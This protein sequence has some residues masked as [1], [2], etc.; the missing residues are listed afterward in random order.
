MIAAFQ[1]WWQGRS[2]RE[3]M[4]L[5]SMFAL[6]LICIGWFAI[7]DS[8]QTARVFAEDRLSRATVARDATSGQ[9]AWI[10]SRKEP[11]IA[12]IPLADLVTG[13]ASEVGFVL[14]RSQSEGEDRLTIEI[15]SARAQALFG[16][17]EALNQRGVFV[18]TANLIAKSDG[19]LSVTLTL[20]QAR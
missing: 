15:A 12:S 16:W 5:G 14:V 7:W 13:S 8:A 1:L 18:E 10:K 9:V 19:A 4:L 2:G 3:Q 17:L 11:A 6:M 20:R